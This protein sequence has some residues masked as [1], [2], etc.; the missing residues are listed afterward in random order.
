MICDFSVRALK[1]FELILKKIWKDERRE[2][3]ESFYPCEDA[4]NILPVFKFSNKK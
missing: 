2:K 3:G 4:Q 1:K